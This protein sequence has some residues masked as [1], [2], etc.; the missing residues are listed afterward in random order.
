[1]LCVEFQ[2]ALSSRPWKDSQEDDQAPITVADFSNQ[3]L[4]SLEMGRQIPSIS[5]V[6]EEDSAS[7]HL[8]N[9]VEQAVD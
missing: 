6:A 7:V 4:I 1:M 3:E 2:K 8:D 9:L 5:L